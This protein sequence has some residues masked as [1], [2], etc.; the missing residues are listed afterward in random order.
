MLN[1]S[2]IL[3]VHDGPLLQNNVDNAFYGVHYTNALVDRYLYLGAEI[4]FLMRVKKISP[5]L[6][7]TFSLLD[8]PKLNVV[9]VPDFKSLQSLW[10]KKSAEV[11][12]EQ[13]VQTSDMIILRMPSA[14]AVLAHRF[15]LQ[16]GK[17]FIIEVVACVFDALW[18]YD[19]RG[20]ILAYPK[21]WSYRKLIKNAPYVIYVTELFLQSRYPTSGHSLGCSDVMLQPIDKRKL[22]KRLEKFENRINQKIIL[23]TV[24]AID[25]PYKGQADVIEVLSRLDQHKFEYWIVGQG[26]PK[27][28][29]LIIDQK[30]LHNIKI[31]GSVKHDEI[32]R[33]LEKADL[34]V[35][36]SRQEGLPRAVIEAMSVGM[37]VIGTNIAGIPELLPKD[38][39]YEPHNLNDLLRL[40]TNFNDEQGAA[41]ALINFEKSKEFQQ[42]EL[43]LKRNQFYSFF[44]NEN[45]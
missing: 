44:L 43:D 6:G 2:K 30:K 4:T 15:A 41:W 22:L 10:K 28:L 21:Y 42:S 26:S 20:K 34:Y 8:H 3:F 33:L 29:Q 25:V 37:P 36:P 12:I 32:F 24:A 16:Y 19:W 1:Q 31:V 7:K 39:V 13:A 9:E 18:N 45:R 40:I 11:I 5:E 17:P 38:C 35:Q 23:I 27:R 14:N